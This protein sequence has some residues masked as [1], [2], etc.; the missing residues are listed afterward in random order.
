MANARR[1]EIE[2]ELGN[3]TWRM[4]L[5]LGALA[6]LEDSFG[7]SDLADLA[8]R[9]SGGRLRSADLIRIIG[10]GFRGAG[11]EISDAEVARLTCADGLAGYASIVAALLLA[12]F[13]PSEAQEA[14]PFVT[15]NASPSPGMM[16]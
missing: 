15:K 16:P 6:E 12:T 3:R 4:C 10:C 13:G 9:F 8:D 14:R 2:A 7:A 1:G 5:T 11:N